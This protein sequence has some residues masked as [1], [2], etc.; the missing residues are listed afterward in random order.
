MDSADKHSDDR[1]I[2]SAIGGDTH[3]FGVLVTRHERAVRRL[4]TA[5][6][7]STDADDVAQDSFVR[8][9]R[10]LATFRPGSPFRPW[11]LRIVANQ[12]GNTRRG[13]RRRERR[14][15]LVAARPR[16]YEPEPGEAIEQTDERRRLIVA[17]SAL[18]EKD[19]QVLII[20]YLLDYSEAETAEVLGCAPG[21]VKSRGSRALAKIRTHIN[22]PAWKASNE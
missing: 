18:P 20:R 21:T 16:A 7:G 2:R 6:V 14:H 8:A 5:L 9:Y 11:L 17:L 1:L 15:A 12:A 19:R 22:T 4:A 10:S 13:T 3:A